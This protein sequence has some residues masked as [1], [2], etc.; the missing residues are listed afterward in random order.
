MIALWLSGL[1]SQTILLSEEWWEKL[2]VVGV[3]HDFLP[4]LIENFV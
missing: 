3:Y 2:L 1:L 4:E